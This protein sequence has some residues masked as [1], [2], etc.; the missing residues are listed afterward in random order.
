M[1]SR[2]DG[3][4]VFDEHGDSSVDN[5]K[6]TGLN[7][8]GMPAI[9]W[10]HGSGHDDNYCQ[11]HLFFGVLPMIPFPNNDHSIHDTSLRTTR[12]FED[13]GACGAC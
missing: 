4:G 3:V 11:R 7:T 10:N 9:I 6:V 13:Y 8:L 2:H 5:M 12:V 1:V